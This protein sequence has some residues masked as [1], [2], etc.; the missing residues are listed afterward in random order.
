MNLHAINISEY[1]GMEYPTVVKWLESHPEAVGE[2]AELKPDKIN[3]AGA[4]ITDR[5]L[6]SWLQVAES[7]ENL[8][9]QEK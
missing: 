5:T 3:L 4:I 9:L 1:S 6:S 8:N 7:T 2:I